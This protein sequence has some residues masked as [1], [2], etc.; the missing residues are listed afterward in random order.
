MTLSI[1]WL[2]GRM[3]DEEDE[4]AWTTEEDGDED[5][6]WLET[7][8]AS[9]RQRQ[10]EGNK[11]QVLLEEEEEQNHESRLK[12]RNHL[13]SSEETSTVYMWSRRRSLT[14]GIQ[15]DATVNP[16]APKATFW[17]PGQD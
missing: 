8:S 5:T 4:E 9:R 3:E 14:V 11:D 10:T 13:R 16:P 15:Q 17:V 1:I 6:F 7:L 12:T 2:T